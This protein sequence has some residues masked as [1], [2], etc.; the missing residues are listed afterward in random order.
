[1]GP[2]LAILQSNSQNLRTQVDFPTLPG[3]PTEGLQVGASQILEHAAR[4]QRDKGDQSSHVRRTSAHPYRASFPGASLALVTPRRGDILLHPGLAA[5][6]EADRF[7]S[8]GGGW[9][10]TWPSVARVPPLRFP[11]WDAWGL[12]TRLPTLSNSSLSPK[13]TRAEDRW[14]TLSEPPAGTLHGD[15]HHPVPWSCHTTFPLQGAES[16]A[17][18]IHVTN[19][20]QKYSRPTWF[21]TNDAV[22]LTSH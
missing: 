14:A 18:S 12:E 10:S 7:P 13:R 4:A 22:A 2:Q 17:S 3:P 5:C 1:V 6:Q 16:P 11:Q 21:P 8:S 15:H 9:T 19:H 20:A